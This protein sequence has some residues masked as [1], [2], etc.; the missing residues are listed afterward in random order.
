MEFP[1][2][3]HTRIEFWKKPQFTRTGMWWFTLVFG[4][5]GL[6]HVM[7]R[8]PQ[9]ALIFV[10]VNLLTLGYPWFYDLIQL[11]SKDLGGMGTED[12]NKFGMSHPWGPLGLA[13]GMW[14]PDGAKP[15]EPSPSDPP[16]PWW[17]VI[18]CFCIPVSIA[19]N[20][21]AGDI[22][23]AFS[24][25]LML[26]IVPLG[27]LF[28]F[29]AIFYDYWCLLGSPADLLFNGTRRFFPFPSLGWDNM[30]H[31]PRLTGNNE[32]KPCPRE[33]VITAAMR[34]TIPVIRYVNP[35]LAN[36][37]QGAISVAT[38]VKDQTIETGQQVINTGMKVGH[39]ATAIPGAVVG[40]MA[41]V[42][43]SIANPQALLDP[44]GDAMDPINR[45][46]VP[47]H[48]HAPSQQ[49]SSVGPLA[50]GPPAPSAPAANNNLGRP[51]PS[52]PPANN[53][54]AKNSKRGTPE[55]ARNSKRSTPESA[56]RP[57]PLVPRPSPRA[58]PSQ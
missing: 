1:A 2:V 31:S 16:S 29:C 38:T 32:F 44:Q 21:V 48:R 40:P 36:T 50:P 20:I 33:N 37:I 15:S 12:L 18:Y 14:L 27:W 45:F 25:F 30:G 11:S 9:T 58:P 51:A 47:G 46:H 43:E 49:P 19:S 3:S 28:Y 5:L 42:A 54:F 41:H 52:A 57:A 26:T 53:A 24:R 13:Q 39:L 17:F 8:S 4:F 35:D 23:N 7:L 6:H 34:S 55:S 56:P 10:I 22:N